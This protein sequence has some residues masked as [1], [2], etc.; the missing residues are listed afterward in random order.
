ML[1]I[2]STVLLQSIL[3]GIILSGIY[4]LIA[5]GLSLIMSIMKILQ[6]AHGEVYMLGAYGVYYFYVISK[7]NF[8]LAILISMALMAFFGLILER[9][10]FRPFRD[11]FL[12]SF[13]VALGLMIM[14][15]SSV[16]VEFGI[17]PKSIPSFASGS[18]RILSTMIGN[19]RVIAVG[20]SIAMSLFLLIFLKSSKYGQALTAAAQ[21]REASILQ[22]INPDHMS[23]IA[24]AV[25]S[26]LAAVGGG[27]MGAILV[28]NPYMGSAALIKGII[29]IVLGGMGSL[30][31]V[32]LGGI[33]LGLID[34]VVLVIFGPVAAS[35]APMFLVAI[36]LV[37]KP[38]GLLGH[39]F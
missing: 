24:M 37:L 1:N 6:F 15:Q 16:A 9:F 18:I 33:I 38:Q 22:G 36:I 12:G 30:P 19:D 23:A 5:L 34:S 14:L 26:A 20:I 32:V 10:F 21:H 39:E 3:N 13:I 27:L 25:G 35:I 31:G 7:L 8:F 29:I 2:S 11:N 17:N 28:M 4:I